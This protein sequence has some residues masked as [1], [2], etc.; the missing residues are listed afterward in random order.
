MLL[1]TQAATEI[2]QF[3]ACHATSEQ[4][5]AFHPSPEVAERADELIYSLTVPHCL[6][7]CPLPAI[8]PA[9]AQKLLPACD[10]V[11]AASEK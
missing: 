6:T 11:G 7:R 10:P 3:L 5:V 4:I 2:T 1:K 8:V 9:E